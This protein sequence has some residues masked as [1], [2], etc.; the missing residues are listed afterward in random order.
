MSSTDTRSSE[1]PS[2]R[3]AA[4]LFEDVLVPLAAARAARG[5]PAYF[6]ATA[7]PGAASYFTPLA[8]ARMAPADFEFPGHGTADGLITALVAYWQASGDAELCALAPGMRALVAA[9]QDEAVESDGSVSV[10]C[11]AMF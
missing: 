4:A 8:V 3:L 11:Y 1:R 10:F 9:L 7:E 2:E 6:P 5:A